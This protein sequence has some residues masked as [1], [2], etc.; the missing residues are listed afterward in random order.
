MKITYL[1]LIITSSFVFA[2]CQ[3]TKKEKAYKIFNEGV[4]LSLDAADEAGKG[5]ETKANQLN[6]NAIDKFK[7][8]L[9]TDATHPIVRSALAHSLYL[10][11][12]YEDAIYWFKKSINI[13]NPQAVNYQE[14]GLCEINL[15]Q[16]AVGKKDIYKSFE[17]DKSKENKEVTVDDLYDIGK[18]AFEFSE[19]YGKES[20]LTDASNYKKFSIE[21][22][23]LCLEIDSTRKDISQTLTKFNS[24]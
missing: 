5:N 11:R 15:G 23:K 3:Q 17:L 24:K 8:A 19:E 14:M 21:V 20:K 18:L 12:K 4:T 7:E 6:Q 9:K 1:I 22:L 13:A 2:S 10:D 16:I